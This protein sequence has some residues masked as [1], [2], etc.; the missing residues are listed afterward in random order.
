M[1]DFDVLK[2]FGSTNDRLR[3]IFTAQAYSIETQV[4]EAARLKKH[5]DVAFREAM[6][7]ELRSRISEHIMFGVR[8]YQLYAAVDMAWDSTPINKSTIPL[9]LYAQGKIDITQCGSSLANLPNSDRYVKK[10]TNGIVKEINMPVFLEV[11][12]NL[13]RSMVTRRLAAQSN[14]YRNLWPYY[15]YESRSTGP[16]GKLRADATSQRMDIMTDQFGYRSHDV[17]LYRDMLL[18]AHGVDFVRSSWEVDK[19]YYR[20]P[21][22]PDLEKTDGTFDVDTII[23]REGVGW[24]NPHP[25]R[26]FWD[27]NYPLSSINTDSGCEYIGYWDVCRYRD[28]KLNPLY[29]NREAISYAPVMWTIWSQYAQYFT[30]YYTSLTPPP[31]EQ[32]VTPDPAGANDRSSN[33][34]VYSGEQLDS[35]VFRT[36]YFA[37]KI[38][39]DIG[40]G[41]YP[42]PVWMRFVVASDHTV[43]YAEILPSTPAAYCGYNESDNR[44]VNISFAHE[45]MP[46]QDQMSN[47]LSE[48]LLL[49]QQDLVAIYQMNTDMLT[50]EQCKFV[51][52]KLKGQDWS[53]KPL[54]VQYSD[55][56]SQ[57]LGIKAREA[58]AVTRAPS[59]QTMTNLF[60]AMAQLLAMADKLA[61]MSPAEQGQPA[62]REISATEVNEISTSTSSVYTFISDSIDEF[63]AA[64]K[65][66]LFDSV[67]ACQQGKVK[68]PVVNRYSEK[69]VKAAGFEIVKEEDEDDSAKPIKR[70]TIL[71]TRKNLIHDYIF[72]TR[73]GAERPVNVQAANTLVQ[74]LAQILPIPTILQAMGKEKLYEL[75]NEVFRLIGAGFDL[76]LE[77][78]EGEDDSLGV[79]QVQQL[80]QELQQVEQ[81]TGQLAQT[82]QQNTA[83]LGQQQQINTRQEEQIKLSMSLAGEVAKHG[84]TIQG[85]LSRQQ[86][87][88]DDIKKSLSYRDA[89]DSIR[90]QM[91]TDAGYTP[92]YGEKSPTDKTAVKSTA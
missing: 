63:H 3:E 64:K 13:C 55:S 85:I 49:A 38:P 86:Q 25:T 32:Q 62:P 14:K 28:I 75:L 54:V 42:F 73:D 33:I 67:V 9:I 57:Q 53:G 4:D 61:V 65:R 80:T 56:Q 19:H 31:S 34:G 43:I 71:G 22:A 44:Q 89:P 6:E 70:R 29:Y 30:Q 11:E 8:N 24:I 26:I 17:Q 47:L 76:K 48:M 83:E 40:C 88:E 72:T 15:K 16:V 60:Q 74:T 52:Q 66:I 45:I 18:Y 41:E 77:L 39:K 87:A 7:T 81:L 1:I 12:F 91:E 59:G 84:K 90:R 82:V 20:K 58:I 46:Y 50:P 2:K 21:V 23:T 36:E 51:E 37:K 78:A 69:T 68:L 10:D 27:N 92:A 35:A 79:D 5:E